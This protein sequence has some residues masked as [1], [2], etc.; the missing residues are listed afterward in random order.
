MNRR[1]RIAIVEDNADNRML[2][3]ELL[4]DRYDIDAY[5]DGIIGLAGMRAKPPRVVLLDI[6]LPSMTGTQVLTQMREDSVLGPIP[7]IALTAHGM[8]DDRARFLAQGFDAYISKPIIDDA[9]LYDTIDR[10]LEQGRIS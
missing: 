10:L 1:P 7:V 2:L 5:E 9:V 4:S 6:S 8:P 3:E